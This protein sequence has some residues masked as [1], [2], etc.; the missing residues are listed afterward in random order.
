MC[1]LELQMDLTM[2]QLRKSHTM[3]FWYHLY[4]F[5]NINLAVPRKISPVTNQQQF[6][7]FAQKQNK[8]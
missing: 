8:K 1:V 7:W 6:Q 5:A 2:I 4:F 3:N